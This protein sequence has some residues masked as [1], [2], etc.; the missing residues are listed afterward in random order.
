MSYGIVK[1]PLPPRTMGL[2][3]EVAVDV[4]RSL[5][6]DWGSEGGS[7]EKRPVQ[8]YSVNVPLVEEV[9][10]PEKRRVCWTRMWR[11]T[12]GQLFKATDL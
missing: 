5:W 2:A 4:C 11:N 9:L 7:G 8:V 6:E 1:R 3:H 10:T 12:Y